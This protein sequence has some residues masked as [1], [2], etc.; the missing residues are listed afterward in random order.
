[1]DDW[2]L[3][4]LATGQDRQTGCSV[5]DADG[6]ST[7]RAN[8]VAP[9]LIKL[10]ALTATSF[11]QQRKRESDILINNQPVLVSLSFTRWSLFFACKSLTFFIFSASFFV[12]LFDTNGPAVS[13][14]LCFSCFQFSQSV[15]LKKLPCQSWSDSLSFL[16][17]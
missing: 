5:G 10:P 17:R 6:Q 2:L 16:T 9:N 3:G 8:Q 12:V 13:G 11:D 7:S 15:L 1:M 14:L 4:K